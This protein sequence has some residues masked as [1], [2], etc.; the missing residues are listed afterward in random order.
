MAGQHG[1]DVLTG[2]NLSMGHRPVGDNNAFI[3]AD[4]IN[5]GIRP[6]FR[7]RSKQMLNSSGS[8]IGLNQLVTAIQD[9]AARAADKAV[10]QEIYTMLINGASCDNEGAGAGATYHASDLGSFAGAGGAA[11]V[12]VTANNVGLIPGLFQ[13]LAEQQEINTS[14]QDP[15]LGDNGLILVADPRFKYLFQNSAWMERMMESN[16]P[17]AC[18]WYRRGVLP[19]TLNDTTMIIDRCLPQPEGTTDAN[20]GYIIAFARGAFG[21]EGFNT[22]FRFFD[23]GAQGP[24][25]I[26]GWGRFAYGHLL[27]FPEAVFVMR[28]SYEMPSA[29]S[30]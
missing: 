5:T 30:V 11:P 17:E 28:V 14:E 20:Y 16:C 6:K 15:V 27:Q 29:F 9:S 1:P 22:E 12:A 4:S 25:D 3:A 18:D 2:R 26:Y 19:G 13:Y 8:T 7:T 21:F 24:G 23:G 10:L